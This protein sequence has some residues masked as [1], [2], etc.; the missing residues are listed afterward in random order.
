MIFKKSVFNSKVILWLTHILTRFY[1]LSIEIFHAK[2]LQYTT[3]DD[4]I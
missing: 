3:I 2:K 1:Q 4:F